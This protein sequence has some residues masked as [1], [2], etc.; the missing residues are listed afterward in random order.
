MQETL[1]EI[2]KFLKE[3]RRY[4]ASAARAVAQELTRAEYT[5]RT[6]REAL[7]DRLAASQAAQGAQ[8]ALVSRIDALSQ[9]EL[10]LDEQLRTLRTSNQYRAIEELATA[11]RQASRDARQAAVAMAREKE[12]AARQRECEELL[13]R[14][15]ATLAAATRDSTARSPRQ[16]RRRGWRRWRASKAVAEQAASGDSAAARGTLRAVL[17]RRRTRSA[18]LRGSGSSCSRRRRQSRAPAFGA[19]VEGAAARAGGAAPRSGAA[20][21]GGGGGAPDAAA[22][23]AEGLQMGRPA[24]PSTPRCRRRPRRGCACSRRAS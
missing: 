22:V 23:W 3:Y 13:A 18:C 5:H 1:G 9:R 15:Q 2:G 12:E 10:G 21:C 6:A 19:E 20:G 14:A 4:V 24:T 11:E 8:A 16:P 17:S 7:R